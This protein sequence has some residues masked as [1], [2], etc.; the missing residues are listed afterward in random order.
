MACTYKHTKT[1]TDTVKVKGIVTA[2]GNEII[3]TNKDG[4]EETMEIAPIFKR[5]AGEGINFTLTSKD[6]MDLSDEEWEYDDEEEVE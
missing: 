4:Q 1:V 2:D 3:F 6:E 5:F